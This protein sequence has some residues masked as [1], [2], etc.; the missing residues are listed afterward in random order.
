M[1]LIELLIQR[2]GA[3]T[4]RAVIERFEGTSLVNVLVPANKLDEVKGLPWSMIVPNDVSVNV[5][6]LRFFQNLTTW[7]IK[8][9]VRS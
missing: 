8:F 2:L 4:T 3:V 9:R 7:S 5:K 6:S 1:L